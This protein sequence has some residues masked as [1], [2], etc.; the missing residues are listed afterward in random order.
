MVGNSKT[1]SMFFNADYKETGP[2]KVSPYGVRNLTDRPIS[3]TDVQ[4]Y[5]EM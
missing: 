3:V 2:D 4:K 1:E 5:M